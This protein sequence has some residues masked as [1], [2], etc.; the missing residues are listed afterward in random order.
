MA[1]KQRGSAADL[2]DSVLASTIKES[3][4]QIWLA[5]LGA[6]SKAQAEGGKVF[7]ALVKEGGILQRHTRQ[8]TEEK[9]SEVTGKVSKVANDL[10]KQANETWD[11]L[12]QV[13]EERVARALRTLGVPTNKELQA[14]HDKIDALAAK[15]PA[16]GNAAAPKKTASKKTAR[17][18]APAKKAAAAP[19][20]SAKRSR[21]G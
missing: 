14:L 2:K 1:K 18:A 7:E 10:S 16:R 19:K 8:S 13:F 21:R 20:A 3:A 17:K 4:S 9:V 5:G 11:R 6:F 15:R 12:E